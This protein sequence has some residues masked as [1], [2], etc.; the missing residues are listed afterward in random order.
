MFDVKYLKHHFLITKEII[1]LL[2]NSCSVCSNTYSLHAYYSVKNVL[3]FGILI[4]FSLIYISWKTYWEIWTFYEIQTEKCFTG[5]SLN[6]LMFCTVCLYFV[7]LNFSV[8]DLML[9][10]INEICLHKVKT[11]FKI[12][13]V[14]HHD[15]CTNSVV[16]QNYV[17]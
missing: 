4:K 6:R 2:T 14:Y 10:N 13:K 8:H 17:F 7:S 5:Q 12:K 11:L 16:H 1:W 9:R 15:L 3:S